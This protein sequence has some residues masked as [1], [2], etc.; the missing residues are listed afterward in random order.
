MASWKSR[1]RRQATPTPVSIHASAC[2]SQACR[3]AATMTCPACGRGFVPTGR[4]R[5]CSTTC[6]QRAWRTLQGTPAAL[7]ARLPGTATVY[8]CEACGTR[9]LG[10]QRCADCNTFARRV[11]PGGPCP[12]CEE[13]VAVQDISPTG[14]QSGR[15]LPSFAREGVRS[16]PS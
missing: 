7:P 15:R 5:Y 6:R 1:R 11:G 2:G 12:H 14:P 10:I 16:N 9:S 4:Q 3:A 13:P 8:E